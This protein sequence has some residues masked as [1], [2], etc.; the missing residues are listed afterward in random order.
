MDNHNVVHATLLQ[1]QQVFIGFDVTLL[2]RRKDAELIPGKRVKFC[3]IGVPVDNG[4][5][6]DYLFESSRSGDGDRFAKMVA[7]SGRIR[8]ILAS[9]IQT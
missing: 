4:Y 3:L 2:G 9:A 7:F 8:Q 6:G 5:Y 1:S